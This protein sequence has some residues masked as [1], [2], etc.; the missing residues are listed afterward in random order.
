MP[1][2]GVW[3]PLL[4][5]GQPP[6]DTGRPDLPTVDRTLPA[7]FFWY[8][9]P[10]YTATLKLPKSDMNTFTHRNSRWALLVRHFMSQ[11][12][13]PAHCNIFSRRCSSSIRYIPHHVSAPIPQQVSISHVRSAVLGRRR[14]AVQQCR[15][16]TATYGYPRVPTHRCTQLSIIDQWST[17]GQRC[18]NGEYHEE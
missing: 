9:R 17:D 1:A 2:T 14:A 13:I 15:V 5:S 10:I 6:V 8:S 11:T 7:D 3:Q 16:C 12:D 18:T 4:D